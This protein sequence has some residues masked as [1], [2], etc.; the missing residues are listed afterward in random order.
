MLLHGILDT[1]LAVLEMEH[2]IMSSQKG[3]GST[4]LATTPSNI[5]GHGN[6]HFHARDHARG[7]GSIA[8]HDVLAKGWLWIPSQR[9][10]GTAEFVTA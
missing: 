3:A 8:Q 1:L 6:H 5:L 4:E 10:A 9:L 2:L 7:Y